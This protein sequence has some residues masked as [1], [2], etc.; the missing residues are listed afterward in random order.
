[1]HALL[2]LAGYTVESNTIVTGTQID[3]VARRSDTLASVSYLVECTDQADPPSLAYIKEKAATLLDADTP[4]DIVCLMVVS[5]S[6]FTA[7]SRNFASGRP[8]LLLR[9][10]AELE[11]GLVDFSP[12]CN[13]YTRNYR[14][15]AGIFS[16]A[17][18]YER[19]IDTSVTADETR[20]SQ[21][22]NSA[23]RAWLSQH[24]NNV[25]F[26]LGDYGAGKT[27]FLRHFTFEALATP[28]E[29]T[30]TTPSP[31]P[32]LIPLREYRSAI[33]L[34]QVITDTLV[35][36]YGVRLT[37]FQ[38]FERFCSLGHALLLFDGFDEMAA[39]SSTSTLVDC[40]AQIFILAETNT[41]LL[42]TCR[43]NFFRSHYQLFE[44][45]RRF[46]IEIT[47]K[48]PDESDQLP[49]GRH[50]A[51]LTL[52]PLSPEQVK[53]FIERRFPG[54]GDQLI[55][56]ISAIHDLSDLCRRPVLLDMILTTLPDLQSANKVV[57]SAALYEHYTDRWTVRDQW[58]LE[59]PLESRQSLCDA[60]AWSFQAGRL[61]HISF[62]DLRSLVAESVSALT[63]DPKEVLKYLNDIQTC[64]FLVRVGED[65]RYEFAHKSFIEYFVARRLAKVLSDGLTLELQADPLDSNTEAADD[66]VLHEWLDRQVYVPMDFK[67]VRSTLLSRLDW[68]HISVGRTPRSGRSVLVSSRSLSAELEQQAARVFELEDAPGEIKKLP[69][70]ISPEIATFTLEW[71]QMHKVRF[72]SLLKGLRG[73]AERRVLIDVLRRANAVEF[74]KTNMQQVAKAIA[75]SDD[76]QFCAAAAGAL[77][78][79]TYVQSADTLR[80]LKRRLG[81]RGF[82]Y[83]LYV[84]AE[85][86]ESA[87]VSALAEL[88]NAGELDEFGSIVATFGQRNVLPDGE[89]ELRMVKKVHAFAEAS[90]DPE[91]ALTLVEF[92]TPSDDDLIRIVGAIVTNDRPEKIKLEATALL[93]RLS[94]PDSARLIRRIWTR[95]KEPAVYKALQKTEER[96]RSKAAQERDRRTWDGRRAGS[97]AE[98]LWRSLTVAP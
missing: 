15:S 71:L 75:Q 25:L 65:D 8:R 74:M 81:S 55:S 80:E 82:A 73:A 6:G 86:G 13:W 7:P 34:R 44:L 70:A 3:I 64:S 98:K 42:V 46:S 32:I 29:H 43:S 14:T 20:V 89:Y 24:D 23:V 58:R 56:Q 1:M 40:L 92:A 26:L 85:S 50:G 63:G 5:R 2:E 27:S 35:N 10:L 78:G 31:I 69:F 88:D 68:S 57:N 18:L 48:T 53:A 21:S 79:T 91:L 36:E 52:A 16:E 9:T 61:K 49:L 94:S 76:L 30:P 17:R 66:N 83:L 77:A 93:D 96:I 51:V 39:D 41:K 67:T 97:T 37:S 84:L 90:A 60:M 59:M 11:A 33:N 38:A 54:L 47:G 4:H 87:A 19:Y 22:L 62:E 95:T 12:Y 28:Q 72:D 45:L